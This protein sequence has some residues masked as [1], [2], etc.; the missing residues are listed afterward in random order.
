MGGIVVVCWKAID[1]CF[2]SGSGSA[3]SNGSEWER[4]G[5]TL[6]ALGE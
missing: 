6:G 4:V 2:G 1:P 5:F 3:Q